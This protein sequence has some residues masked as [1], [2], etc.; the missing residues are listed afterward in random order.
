M[1]IPL[2]IVLALLIAPP[3]TESWPEF[4]GPTGDG[5]VD[6]EIP[7]EWSE[8]RN[9]AW[10]T[11]IHGRGWSTPVVLGRQVWLTTATEDGK[12]MS[13]LCIDRDTGKVLHDRVLFRNEKPRPLGNPVNCYASPS[14]AIERGRVHV[15]FGSYGTA[16]LDTRTFETIWERRDLPCNHFRGPASS[17]VLFEDMLIL[18]MDGSDHQYVVALDTATGR[19]RWKTDRSTDYGDLDDD[20]KPRADGDF[21]KAFNTPF[22]VRAAGR[23]QMISPG[24]KAVFSYDP[25][26]GKEIWTVRYGNHSSASRTVVADGLALINTGY[27]KAQLWAV[28]L[29]GS[30]DVTDTHVVWK[31][32]QSVPNR[33]SPLVTDGLILMCT[34]RGIASCLEAATGTRVWQERIGGNYSASPIL[35]RGRAYFF[36]EDGTT[37]VIAASREFRVLTRNTLD[38]GMMASPAVAGRELYLR[39]RTHLYRIEEP[40]NAKRREA[41]AAGN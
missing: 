13:V 20:G 2:P 9:V 28:R 6:A 31:C 35:A 8:T 19:T 14:P 38:D 12:A 21:R 30:G 41:G 15:T 5:R 17:A 22:V 4:R 25:A 3:G 7:L 40:R 29:D 36:A 26:T 23:L 16:C 24:A 11:P 18:Q 33:S 10:K 34:D 32:H 37:T 1:T 39:T 27:P